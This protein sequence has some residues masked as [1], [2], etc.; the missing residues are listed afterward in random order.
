MSR[1]SS[2]AR[3][4]GSRLHDDSARW[5]RPAQVWT[6]LLRAV[7]GDPRRENR[8]ALRRLGGIFMYIGLGTILVIVLIVLVILF[9][10]R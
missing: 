10:R 8:D 6:V 5:L 4:F 3:I 1:G 7:H 2:P 9:L